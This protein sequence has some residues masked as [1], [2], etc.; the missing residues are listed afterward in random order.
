MSSKPFFSILMCNYNNAPYLK[1]AVE[2]VIN[3]TFADWELSYL[4][5]CSTDNSQEIIG[6]LAAKE[7]RIKIYKNEQNSGYGKSLAK[8]IEIANGLYGAILDPDDALTPD[9]LQTMHGVLSHD[10]N[11]VG[12]YSQMYYCDE[13]LK[14]EK[15]FEFTRKVLETTTYLEHGNMAMTHFFVFDRAKFISHGNLDTNYRNAL[16]QDWYY[17]IEEIGK[18][19]FVEK[20]LY[21]YRVSPTG[22][23]QGIK[24]RYATYKDHVEIA[25]NAVRRRNITGRKK[26]RIIS[27]I[28]SMMYFAKYNMEKD[29]KNPAAKWSL[30]KSRLHQLNTKI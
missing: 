23:S 15:V 3:Q 6:E 16:D 1:Q 12:A 5:D 7:P 13:N 14:P 28:K 26:S 18:V 2:S 8:N 27:K 9:A 19:A 10:K 4:D 24:K 17:K 20:P 30:L 21:Y 25:K 11:L 29:E 22:L